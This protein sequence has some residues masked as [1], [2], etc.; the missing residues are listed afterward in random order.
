MSLLRLDDISKEFP[1]VKALEDVTLEINS[2][3]VLALLGENGAGKSTLIKIIGGIHAPDYG[4]VFYNDDEVQ[5]SG[6]ADAQ[7]LGIAII[8]QELNLIPTLSVR[9]NLFLG[10]EKKLGLIARQPEIKKAEKIL[11]SL[12]A[13]ISLNTPCRRLSVAQ[14]QLVEIARALLQD[15]RLLVMDE[16]TTALTEEDVE[17]LFQT[18]RSLKRQGIAIIY[19]THRLAEVDQVADKLFFLRDGKHVGTRKKGEVDRS[20]MIE[21]MVGRKLDQEF[22]DHKFSPGEFFL[23]V[24]NLNSPGKIKNASFQVRKGEILGI[25]GL[26]G[27]GRTELVRLIAGAD[28]PDSGEV[29]VAGKP[30]AVGDPRTSIRHGI[31]M[32]PEDRKSQGLVLG[33][34]V[35]ENFGLVN[36]D[37]YS[38]WGWISSNQLKQ[39]L[40]TYLESLAI[41]VSGARQKALNLSGGNQQKLVL[42]KWLEKNCD[43]II[44]D[45]PTRGID[46]GA[47]FEIYQLMHRLVDQGKCIIMVS[48][49]LPEI[50]GMANRVLV[51]REGEIVAQLDEVANLNQEDIM[52]L[53]V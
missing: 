5:I 15:I 26:M 46:V 41:K 10:S 18:I 52:S 43:V 44:F 3:E 7:Q 17:H 27:S 24:K 47:K 11:C 25:T 19:I 38:K 51:M 40:K 42:A 28:Q 2:G 36:L 4:Q 50:L 31:G 29:V 48:S 33:M 49:E 12:G 23:E 45:E 53:S 13:D 8:H 39:R 30:I 37:Q 6:P 32:L 9:D 14:Q 20:A 16:P 22:P 21:L 35:A 34:S 1:G